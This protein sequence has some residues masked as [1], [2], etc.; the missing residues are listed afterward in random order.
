GATTAVL[1]AVPALEAAGW[2]F[3]FWAPRPSPVAE[4]L[5]RRGWAVTGE[6]RPLRYSWAALR[7][8]P[9]PARRLAATPGYLRRLRAHIL[10]RRP[11]LVHVNTI[12]GLPEA[13][14]ARSTRT[15]TLLHVHEMLTAGVRGAAAARLAGV[16]HHTATDSLA[17]ARPLR[18]RGL[19]T[20]VVTPGLALPPP[21]PAPSPGKRPLVV[22]TLA[23][24]SERKG[25]DL[26]VAAASALKARRPDVEFRM[27]GWLAPGRERAWAQGLT[28]R[29]EA[30]GIRWWPTEDPLGELADWDVF[31]LPTRRD[32]FPLAVLDALG[33]GL[34]VV[35]TR[36]DGLPEQVDARSGVLVG[37]DDPGALIAAIGGLLDDAPRRAALGAG[38]RARVAA[39]FTPG[40]HARELA[41]AYEATLVAAGRTGRAG[42]PRSAER[43]LC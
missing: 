11:D 2:R 13:A 5:D 43:R 41:A 8:A 40:R 18:A 14:V 38:G 20:S 35:A 19:G 4:L 29:A 25:S 23:T 27:V 37:A 26:F 6:E 7:E 17:C 42:G 10:E 34:P 33:T 36:V 39:D 22:G 24:V 16:A 28:R 9:G 31:V 32:P 15:P 1:R 21:R 12:V 3:S 30:V